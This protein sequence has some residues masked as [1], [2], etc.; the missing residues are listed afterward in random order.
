MS[1][2]IRIATS[3]AMKMTVEAMKRMSADSGLMFTA[4]TNTG[5][6]DFAAVRATMDAGYANYPLQPGVMIEDPEICPVHLE[7]LTPA[8][9]QT[10]HIVLYIHGGG[11]VCGSAK[12]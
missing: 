11:F 12:G 8:Q 2:E 5:R 10:E 7:R 3:T 9:L 4:N 6:I 1:K